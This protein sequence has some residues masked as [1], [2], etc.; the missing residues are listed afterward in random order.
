[1]LK[2]SIVEC[3]PPGRSVR[4]GFIDSGRNRRGERAGEEPHED[5]GHT[6][7]SR[8]IC[9]ALEEL[10]KLTHSRCKYTDQDHYSR[11]YYGRC[12]YN[13]GRQMRDGFEVNLT[14]YL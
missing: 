1:M 6:S 8:T 11:G 10:V 14:T 3:G 13:F 12:R 2:S 4:A 5:T 9:A 7:F